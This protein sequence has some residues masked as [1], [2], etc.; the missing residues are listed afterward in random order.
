MKFEFIANACGI[1]TSDEEIKILT[2]PWIVNG[3]FDGSW[4]HY[5]PLKTT[6]DDLQDVDAIYLSHIHPDHYDPRNFNFRKDIP[7][8]V[9]DHGK[10]FLHKNLLNQGYT[11]LIPIKDGE[12]IKFEDYEI[13]MFSGFTTHNFFDSKM[14]TLIDSAMV[15]ENNGLVAFNANDNKPDIK[16]CQQIKE[17]FGHIDLALLNSNAAGPYPS[18]FNNLSESEK[19]KE[20]DLILKKY[21][22]HS[23]D[24][25]KALQPSYMI[26]FA[27]FYVLGGTYHYKNKY[28]AAATSDSCSEYLNKKI[29]FDTKVICLRET[30]SFDI[31]KG[32]SNREYFPIDLGEA[33]NYIKNFLSLLKYDYENDPLP[34]LEELTKDTK[35][36]ALNLHDR[37]KKFGYDPDM[38]LEID[39]EGKRINICKPNSNS[40]GLITCSLDYRL[41][42]RILDKESNWNNA[43]I[44]CH[45]EFNRTPNYFSPDLHTMMSFFHL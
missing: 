26:P 3:V 31:R 12:K 29:D 25:L 36:A 5:P 33:D 22:N 35:I 43:E 30:D 6:E 2:D 24:C 11:N 44:G 38:E 45:I 39:I 37:W 8:F 9:L 17:K 19:F 15:L 7:I 1:F 13:T 34:N 32:S 16:S 28:L 4:C 20:K 14:G 27:G 21:F 10:N 23:L 42:R 18:C 41:L 40:K